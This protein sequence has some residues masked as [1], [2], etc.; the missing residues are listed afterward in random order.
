MRFV[1]PKNF[2]FVSLSPLLSD[3]KAVAT[4][5]RMENIEKKACFHVRDDSTTWSATIQ[6]VIAQSSDSKA[7]SPRFCG[8]GSLS[9][10]TGQQTTTIVNNLINDAMP[11][12]A[13]PYGNSRFSAC[14]SAT[15]SLL[16]I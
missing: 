15:F 4:A 8:V 9:F 10:S 1:T 5:T 14:C 13:P 11:S 16:R 12:V 7:I 6:N 3:T 2:R